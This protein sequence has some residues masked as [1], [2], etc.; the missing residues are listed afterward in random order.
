MSIRFEDTGDP[1]DE[2]ALEELETRTGHALPVTYRDFLEAH[3]GAVPEANHLPDAAS[4]SEVSV[5]TFLSAEEAL[6][7][8]DTLGPDRVPA[9]LLPISDDDLGNGLWINAEDGS[10]WS[11]DHEEEDPAEEDLWAA[12]TRE[13][14]DLD[15][16]LDRLEP[17]AEP[18]TDAEADLLDEGYS[19]AEF[20]QDGGDDSLGED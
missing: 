16:L 10:I 9:E 4:G 14:E 18:D 8:L 6:R 2:E 11:Y 7:T 13:A 3:D 20:G 17:V 19:A 1:A 15:E 12:F 5:R